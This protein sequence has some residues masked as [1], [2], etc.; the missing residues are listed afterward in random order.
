VRTSGEHKVVVNGDAV[1]AVKVDGGSGDLNLDSR[2]GH[3]VPVV[4]AGDIVQVHNPKGE[5]ILS[6]VFGQ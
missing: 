5:V 3:K 2:L 6:G 1:G 4:K